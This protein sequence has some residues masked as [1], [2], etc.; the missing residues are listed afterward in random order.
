MSIVDYMSEPERQS[1][2]TLIA[3]GLVFVWFWKVMA[4]GWSLMPDNFSPSELGGLYLKLVIITIIYHAVISAAFALKSRNEG[5]DRDERDVE[6]QSAGARA[7]YSALQIGLGVVI[8]TALLGYV[9]GETYTPPISLD[10]PVQFLFALTMVSYGADLLR[11]AVIVLR[12]R[13]A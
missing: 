9:I 8:V 13:A 5:L 10:T 2:V 3:D 7:G 11:H 12:Y 1:W 6:I 4:P